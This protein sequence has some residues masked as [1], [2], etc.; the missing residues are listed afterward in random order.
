[1]N[2]PI[3]IQSAYLRDYAQRNGMN[4]RLPVTEVC[5]GGSYYS[6][7]NIFRAISDD[8]NFGAVSILCLPLE[9]E[10]LYSRIISLISDRKGIVFHFPLEGFV[11]QLNEL[12]KWRSQFILMARYRAREIPKYNF[13]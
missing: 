11:G 12:Q 5:N 13:S 3:P 9:D 6:L 1:M 7:S 8:E 4:F 2:I 10:S